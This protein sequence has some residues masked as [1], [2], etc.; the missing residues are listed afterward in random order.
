MSMKLTSGNRNLIWRYGAYQFLAVHYNNLELRQS[1][2]KLL[3]PCSHE[4]GEDGY[5][6]DEP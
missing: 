4:E 2:N 3:C 5:A 1:P 6:A